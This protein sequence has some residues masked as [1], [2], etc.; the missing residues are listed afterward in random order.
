MPESTYQIPSPK[1]IVCALTSLLP[2]DCV[3]RTSEKCGLESRR[4]RIAKRGYGIWK[5]AFYAA[6]RRPVAPRETPQGLRSASH[7]GRASPRFYGYTRTRRRL[8]TSA[9]G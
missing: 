8:S 9:R 6:T 1:D 5:G 4:V 7:G 2:V 3:F